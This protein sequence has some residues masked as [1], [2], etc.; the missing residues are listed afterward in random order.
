MVLDG[1]SPG[2]PGSVG[3]FHLVSQR[4]ADRSGVRSGTVEPGDVF[5]LGD[6]GGT[7]VAPSRLALKL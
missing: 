1:P 7:M 6:W 2:R 3:L 4:A 5:G